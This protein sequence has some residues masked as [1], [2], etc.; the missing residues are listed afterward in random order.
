MKKRK[1]HLVVT[2]KEFPDAVQLIGLTVIVLDGSG[3]TIN[4]FS[5]D[6]KEW[7]PRWYKTFQGLYSAVLAYA[8]ANDFTVEYRKAFGVRWYDIEFINLG[9]YR[10]INHYGLKGVE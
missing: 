1:A 3:H 8:E 10:G 4:L 2:Y 5:Y 7:K 6:P 9:N